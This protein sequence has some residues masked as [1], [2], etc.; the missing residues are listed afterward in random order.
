MVLSF[1]KR[2][3]Y[4]NDDSRGHVRRESELLI[5]DTIFRCRRR[6]GIIYIY[7]YTSSYRRTYYY[8]YIYHRYTL[9]LKCI[10]DWH[11]VNYFRER[12]FIIIF[13]LFSPARLHHI[14]YSIH[15]TTLPTI[16]YVTCIQQCR[17]VQT[18][19]LSHI[20]L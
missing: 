7:I 8:I 9:A 2:E 5:Y 17:G 16:F 19:D 4:F 20:S 14:L 10:Y 13:Y 1:W 18:I 15:S 3:F 6:C 11:P 12:L